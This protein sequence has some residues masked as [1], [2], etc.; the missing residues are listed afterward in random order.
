MVGGCK[1]I[2]TSKMSTILEL[3][4][5]I[6][7]G[8][9]AIGKVTDKATPAA[10]QREMQGEVAAGQRLFEQGVIVEGYMDANYTNVYL[11]LEC[12]S[13]SAAEA[14]CATYPL[15]QLGM[16]AFE[17]IPLLG[18]PAIKQSLDRQ[19]LPFACLVAE[20]RLK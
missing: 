15:V 19:N 17:F 5:R 10:M 18:L 12:E 7:C 11:L 9:L 8:I 16:L 14:A 2:S 3:L 13:V 1:S 20:V 6:K 4:Q